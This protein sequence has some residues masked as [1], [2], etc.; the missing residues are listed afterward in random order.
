MPPEFQWSLATEE[1][2]TLPNDADVRERQ[3]RQKPSPLFDMTTTPATHL[4]H[5]VA[6][7]TGFEMASDISLVRSICSRIES[8]VWSN[9]LNL[10]AAT[11]VLGVLKSDRPAE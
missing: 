9:L 4:V 8:I 6:I 2:V 5:H 7:P 3:R 1:G 11:S 10:T